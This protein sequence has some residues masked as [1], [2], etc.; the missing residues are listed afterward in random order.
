LPPPAEIDATY[1][2]LADT[3]QSLRSAEIAAG[4]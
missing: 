2:L 4:S 1:R 3:P